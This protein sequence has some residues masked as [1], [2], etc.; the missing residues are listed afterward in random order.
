M[1]A[2]A[3]ISTQPAFQA[4]KGIHG[5]T[6]YHAV[7]ASKPAA[8][9]GGASVDWMAGG[10]GV[11]AALCGGIWL[12]TPVVRASA[13]WTEIFAYSATV[14]VCGS[15]MYFLSVLLGTVLDDQWRVWGTLIAAGALG[16]LTSR[17]SIAGVCGHISRDG[18]GLADSGAC[19][20]VGAD[21]VRGGIV[22][23]VLLRSVEG[24]TGSG[25]LGGNGCFGTR[26]GWKRGSNC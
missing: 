14:V 2:G 4:T 3:G 13:T 9:G 17:A 26:A 8:A 20:A 21:G 7:A 11:T 16:W 24:G 1:L 23:G 15:A 10:H 22:C 25:V 19:D 5:S 6:L 18:E 12:V